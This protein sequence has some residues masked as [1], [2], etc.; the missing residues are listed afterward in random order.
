MKRIVVIL[1]A[2]S[3]LLP[4]AA[5][6]LIAQAPPA[7]PCEVLRRPVRRA[8][9]DALR[10]STAR[11]SRATDADVILAMHC[12]PPETPDPDTVIAQHPAGRRASLSAAIR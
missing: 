8:S 6:G 1:L 10:S 3:P 11:L 4:S 5:A 9:D 2:V 7:N 12:P